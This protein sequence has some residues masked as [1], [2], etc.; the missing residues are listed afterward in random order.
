MAK[1]MKTQDLLLW[2][3]AGVMVGLAVL[4]IRAVSGGG[5]LGQHPFPQ[6]LSRGVPFAVGGSPVWPIHPQSTHRRE[7]DLSYKDAAGKWHASSARAF[8]ASRKDRHHVGIDIWA[9]PGDVVVAPEDGVIVAQQTFLLGTDA[10]LIELDSGITVLLGEVE[11]GGAKEFGLK[12]GSR[13]RRGEPVTRVGLSN[14][15]SHMLHLETY[16]CCPRKNIRWY[17]GSPANAKIRDPTDWL[18][19]AKANSTALA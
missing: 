15:G 17:K 14:V 13:V 5:R 10:M 7:G 6:A 9:A 1:R 3:T 18:L 19:R 16:A 12:T 8:K 11:R 4:K 2:G